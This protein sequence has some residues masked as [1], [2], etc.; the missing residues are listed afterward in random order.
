MTY[1]YRRGDNRMGMN[2][3]DDLETL[4]TDLAIQSAAGFRVF[5]AAH[6]NESMPHTLTVQCRQEAII[7]KHRNP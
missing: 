3:L 7:P 6:A 4:P 1:V 5:N 2:N